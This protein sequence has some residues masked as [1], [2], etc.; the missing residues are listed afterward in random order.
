ML[1]YGPFSNEVRLRMTF[2]LKILATFA[3]M[4]VTSRSHVNLAL[5]ISDYLYLEIRAMD[6]DMRYNLEARKEEHSRL[7]NV[8]I[9][10]SAPAKH[11]EDVI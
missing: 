6:S 9:S 1:R 2:T 10:H 5:S 11:M 4:F 3:R 8:L 7:R